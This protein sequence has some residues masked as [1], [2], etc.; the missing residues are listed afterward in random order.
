MFGNMNFLKNLASWFCWL[1]EC[2]NMNVDGKKKMFKYPRFAHVDF[3]KV[4][5]LLQ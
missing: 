4:D 1:I 2:L 5:E 3:L